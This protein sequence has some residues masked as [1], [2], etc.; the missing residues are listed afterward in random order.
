[1]ET[2]AHLAILHVA[3]A[4]AINVSVLMGSTLMQVNV[5]NATEVA[6]HVLHQHHAALALQ[7]H[8]SAVS[9]ALQGALAATLTAVKVVY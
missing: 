5:T 1:M 2:R 4:L 7:V 9:A 8:L 3:L 6:A